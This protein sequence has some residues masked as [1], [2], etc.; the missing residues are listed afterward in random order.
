ME[1][2]NECWRLAQ[3][4]Q[5]WAEENQHPHVRN[6]FL[7]MAKGWAQVAL[8]DHAANFRLGAAATDA[9]TVLAVVDPARFAEPPCFVPHSVTLP[10]YPQHLLARLPDRGDD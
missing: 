10:V 2:E 4:C 5:R 6:A 7:S 1:R 9:Q 3:Y 8:Q